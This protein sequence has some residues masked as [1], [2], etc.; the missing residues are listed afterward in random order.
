[1][2]AKGRLES[3]VLSGI[4][5]YLE[6]RHDAFWWRQNTVG[7]QALSG[8]YLHAEKGVSDILCV[9]HGRFFGIEVKREFGGVQSEDQKRFQRNVESA[10]G[11]YVLASSVED[12]DRALGL[13]GPR[14]AIERRPPR[15]YPRGLK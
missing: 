10:G 1:M 8:A 13:R 11:T 7:G 15:K 12:V 4:L 5:A 2:K 9:K 3:Q 14:I 6:F